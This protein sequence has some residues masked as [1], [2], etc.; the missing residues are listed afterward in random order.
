MANPRIIWTVILNR[1]FK[2]EGVVANVKMIGP[3]STLTA[4]FSLR[5][6]ISAVFFLIII[7]SFVGRPKM[8]YFRNRKRGLNMEIIATHTLLCT[9]QFDDNRILL[10]YT[11]VNYVQNTRRIFKNISVRRYINY[12]RP[13]LFVVPLFGSLL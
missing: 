1:A 12:A 4:I 2:P 3:M 10:P 9:L 13:D 6:G 8:S 7:I 11:P 5:N